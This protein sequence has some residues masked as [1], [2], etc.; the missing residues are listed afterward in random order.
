VVQ[1]SQGLADG[2]EIAEK[3]RVK[4]SSTVLLL[5]SIAAAAAA[6]APPSSSSAL[7]SKAPNTTGSPVRLTLDEALKLAEQYSPLLQEANAQVEGATSAISTARAYPNPSFQFLAGPQRARPIA[8]PAVP[9][10]LQHYG[11]SQQLETP[12]VRR[13][14]RTAAELAREST[15]IGLIGTKLFIQAGVKRAFYDVIRRREEIEHAEENLR[16]LEDLRRRTLVQVNVG[17]AAKLELTRS[18]AEVATGQNAVR[19]ANISYVSAISALRAAISAPL[20]RPLD[21]I[22]QLEG[23]LHLPPI[24]QLREA[25]LANNPALKQANAEM[26]RAEALLASEKAL[27]TPQPRFDAEYE[28][29]P[30]LTFYRFGITLPIPVFD[31]RR[32][33]IGEASANVTRASA[34]LRQ[35]R[36]ELIAE[37]ERAYGQ[38]EIA[39]QQVNSFQ[40]GALRQAN[41]AVEAAQAAYRFGARGIIEVLDAQ[42]VLQTVRGEL[43]D[44]QFERQ[45]AAVDLESL[46]L[47]KLG[48]SN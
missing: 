6:P 42:R 45:S 34:A 19:T 22:G 27:R 40:S 47:V 4:V 7:N 21:P 33:Q 23:N 36:L 15:L 5:W 24:D 32:G 44:A 28:H 20:D 9:G 39:D 38:Y 1:Y 8:N 41:A 14:R 35:Q 13:T 12:N 43:L 3:V 2:P 46:G 48:V 31:K 29:Q 16:I 11:V 37:L 18:E 10:L 30:D 26:Q 17:E 25:L